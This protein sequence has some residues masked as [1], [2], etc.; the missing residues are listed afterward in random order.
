M[1]R[2]RFWNVGDGDAIL[3]EEL[4]GDRAFRMLVDTGT[5]AAP[6]CA[7]HLRRAEITRLDKLV[8]THLH[9]DHIG[10]LAAIA[11]S[12]AVGELICGYI[13]LRAGAQAPLE[14]RADKPVRNMIAC[15]N[16]FSADAALLREKGCRMTE[17]FASWHGVNLTENLSA[18]FIVPDLRALRLQREVWNRML[19][20]RR[21]P[22][23]KRIRAA[24]LRNP[25]SLR[26][27]LR[28]AGREI[29][30]AGDCYAEV[31]EK[32]DLA[33]CD[34]LK[35]PHHGDDKS[36]TDRLLSKLKPAHSV[37][38]C[39]RAGDEKRP[40]RRT[41]DALARAGTQ[42][43]FSDGSASG[44]EWPCADFAILDD[45]TIVPPSFR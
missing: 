8:I 37:I 10:G 11:E 13:P 20:P 35:L 21:V 42:V 44:E 15:L 32:D 6:L 27:R 7:D 33:P 36:V 39:D 9:A 26:V 17:L 40:A 19:E 2:I 41:V 30:L 1:L 28:Y 24:K 12:C 23:A 22:D 31:W 16:R 38:C 5:G 34:I 45:G 18:D 43:W 25:N 29:E 4:S 3:I 14:P